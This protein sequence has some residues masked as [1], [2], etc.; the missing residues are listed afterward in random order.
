M[1][2]GTPAGAFFLIPIMFFLNTVRVAP[3]VRSA[4]AVACGLTLS[5]AQQAQAVEAVEDAVGP[6]VVTA[7]RM[8]DLLQTAAIGATVI[9]AEQMQRAGVSDANEAIRKLAGV[10]SR[11]DLSN[12]RDPSLD[13][14]GYG[15]AAGANVVV[16]LDG[17]RIS[18]NENVSARISSIPL[19]QIDRIEIVRGSSSVLWG[20]G[21]S[22]G[23]INII[24]K[25]GARNERSARL[26]A[27]V[28]S[29]RGHEAQADGTWGQ[30]A[31]VFD[32]SARRV[33]SDGFRDNSGFKQDSGSVGAQWQQDGWRA[34]FRVLQEDQYSRLPGS[35][36]LSQFKQSPRQT[37]SPD[38]D[39]SNHETRYLGNLSYQFDAWT[40]Q[41]DVGQRQRNSDYQY[42]SYGSPRVYSHSEQAQ[43]SPRVSYARQHGDIGVKAV[44]GL[45]WQGWDFDK[46]GAAGR[47]VGQQENKAFFTHADL[48]L[49]TQTRVS[50]GWRQE[51]VTKKDDFPGDPGWGLA[52]LKYNR[53]DKL[54]AGELGLNQTLRTGL[55]AYVR[56]ATSYRLPN[57]DENRSTPASA[58]LRP[59]RNEDREV[60][61]K[62]GRSGHSA[63]VRYFVQKT[64]DEIA[65]DN[66]LYANTNIDPTRRRGLEVEGRWSV[67]RDVV[68]SGTWQQ[69]TA[70]YRAGVN[71][72]KE[73]VLVAPHTATVR[74]AWRV[75]DRQTL[76]VGLQFL[77]SMRPGGDEA[78]TCSRRVP[79]STLL[80]ARYAWTDK[81][82]TL[83]LTGTNLADHR[84][85]NYAYSYMC[86]EPSVYPFNGRALK[87]T[88]SRQF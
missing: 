58:A 9:T 6:V 50:A 86:G 18:E 10:A 85:Y 75:D 15:D 37:Q 28:A 34:G 44:A 29:Y 80:D 65:F 87:F 8:S 43:V 52:P 53:D 81:V 72:G 51:R 23:A 11:S 2:A 30:G 14:R 49:P 67:T 57:I 70:R 42:V 20:E 46:S 36:T 4:L 78:N 21:A 77:S 73:M 71:A 17:I 88:A 13:L 7:T 63:T 27:S 59:Q 56:A 83:A 79:S 19:S 54:H 38:D 45:D 16:L 84:G 47:E 55:D 3:G 69:L 68:L 31:W 5:A 1:P 48:T 74:A 66:L 32:A 40:A 39:A 76:D 35:L 24:L 33:R 64:T 60:G 61:L 62:W 12:G 82:W 41:L 26:S 22:A 25:H